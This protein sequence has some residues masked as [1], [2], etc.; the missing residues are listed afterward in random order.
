MS[1]KPFLEPSPEQVAFAASIINSLRGVTDESEKYDI[2]I[3]AVH[4]YEAYR[5]AQIESLQGR[6]VEALSWSAKPL[7]W[8]EI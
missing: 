2:V 7:Q 1:D 3:C 4:G 6:L 8:P 5:R